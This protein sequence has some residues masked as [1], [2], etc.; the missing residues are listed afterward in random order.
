MEL[1]TVT[2]NGCD[3]KIA[4][5]SPTLAA[6]NFIKVSKMV[7]PLIGIITDSLDKE[8]TSIDK[9]SF[10]NIASCLSEDE[11]AY[12]FDSFFQYVQVSKD[13]KYIPLKNFAESH[14]QGKVFDMFHLLFECL[15]FNYS[16]FFLKLTEK[17]PMSAIQEK[18]GLTKNKSGQ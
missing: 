1:N 3:Y 15:K 10:V 6:R 7:I 11:I 16:D 9:D 4:Y 2:I 5:M 18:V 13:G 12:L 8:I 17:I 14:F